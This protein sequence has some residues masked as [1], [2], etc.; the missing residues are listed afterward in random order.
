MSCVKYACNQITKILVG[1]KMFRL[2][3]FK[4]FSY[5]IMNNFLFL[6]SYRFIS[7]GYVNDSQF[8]HLLFK[9]K[10]NNNEKQRFSPMV[11]E[12]LWT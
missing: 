4:Y 7:L 1:G 3:I 5:T 12:N 6:F 2:S 9:K 11:I 8:P 10:I